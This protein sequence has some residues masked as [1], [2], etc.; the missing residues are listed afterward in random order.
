MKLAGRQRWMA[1][2]IALAAVLVSF[3]AA[4]LAGREG[5]PL[6]LAL[7]TLSAESSNLLQRAAEALPLGYAFGAGMA[8]TANPC[9]FALVPA[10]LALQL[11]GAAV[12][13]R[14]S[15][16]R[17]ALVGRALAIGGAASAGFVLLFGGMG[18]ALSTGASVLAVY[19]PLASLAVGLLFIVAGSWTL[20]GASPSITLPGKLAGRFTR[21]PDRGGLAGYFAFGVGFG[22]ASLS[23][24][25]PIFLTVVA[26]VLTAGG[27]AAG[28]LRFVL[29]ALGMGLVLTTVAIAVALAEGALVQRIRKVARYV[30][31]ASGLLLVISGAYVVF[32]WLTLGGLLAQFA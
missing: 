17:A 16:D 27:L 2:G 30:Y 15:A 28:L 18:L 8:A 10:Y 19:L 5:G 24:T 21:P 6:A 3:D 4:L 9:G 20:A 1:P 25:L 32:Y 7:A 23:C 31:L 11:R 13:D 22:L 29:Y 12:G 14:G 26:T